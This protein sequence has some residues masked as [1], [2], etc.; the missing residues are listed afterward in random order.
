[1]NRPSSWGAGPFEFGR[2]GISLPSRGY[3][4]R[5][6]APR[7]TS[8]G[9]VG[10]VLAVGSCGR[11]PQ[12]WIRLWDKARRGTRRRVPRRAGEL[13]GLS[14]DRRLSR[15]LPSV[16]AGAATAVA[17]ARRARAAAATAARA[18]RA[19]AA[20]ATTAARARR[21]RAAAAPAAARA[22]RAV[23]QLPP[24][25]PEHVAHVVRAR[26][27]QEMADRLLAPPPDRRLGRAPRKKVSRGVV[28]VL[29]L[30][31]TVVVS[32]VY[33]YVAMRS[34]GRTTSEAAP[35]ESAP[36]ESAPAHG[37]CRNGHR[38]R[39]IRHRH[40][41]AGRGRRLFTPDSQGARIRSRPSARSVHYLL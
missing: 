22:R 34:G 41:A 40:H 2:L 25:P 26:E 31:I 6:C 35:V 28:V 10:V 16:R 3:W 29:A 13:G 32:G 21:A 1:M 8:R 18:R 5:R 30:A 38:L 33:A 4:C 15:G 24:P 17:S 9:R 23:L 36:V 11:T 19:R 14:D 39:G 12:E 37:T 7:P 20:A 27:I